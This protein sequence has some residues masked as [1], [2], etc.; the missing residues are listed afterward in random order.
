MKLIDKDA[1]VAEIEKRRES[2]A[3]DRYFGRLVEDNYFLNFIDTLKV[4]GVDLEHEVESYW[5][6]C[7]MTWCRD[8]YSMTHIRSMLSDIAKHSVLFYIDSMQEEPTEVKSKCMYTNDNYTDEDRKVLCE[9]CEEDCKIMNTENKLKIDDFT[10]ALAECIHQAQCAVVDPMAHAEIWKEELLELAKGKE[11]A[12]GLDNGDMSIERWKQAVEAASNQRSYRSSK[13]LTENRDDY[14]VD[15]VQWADEHPKEEPVSEVWHDA[16]EE[17]PEEYRDFA[18][19]D[20]DDVMWSRYRIE[21]LCHIWQS[22][23][24]MTGMIKWAYTSD[25]IKL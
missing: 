12:S 17:Q 11:P 7:D 3:K 20:Y 24:N 19:V 25:L 15:G 4:K 1:L 16:N 5:K 13:G 9:G 18:F 10:R 6:Q 22:Y 8:A 21:D 23:V 2:N 14:F